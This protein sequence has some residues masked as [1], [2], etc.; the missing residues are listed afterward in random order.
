VIERIVIDLEICHGKTMIRGMRI[1]VAPVM[2][3]LVGGMSF[4]E[5]QLGEAH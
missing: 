5:V 4:K 3:S 2:G 1:P